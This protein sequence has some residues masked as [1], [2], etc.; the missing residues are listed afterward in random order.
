MDVTKRC[1]CDMMP[2]PVFALFA[3]ENWKVQP[4]CH[5]ANL[6][7]RPNVDEANIPEFRAEQRPCVDWK[8]VEHV[9]SKARWI[10]SLVAFYHPMTAGVQHY[11]HG[12]SMYAVCW[13]S[14]GEVKIPP[15]DMLPWTCRQIEGY[16]RAFLV[17][18]VL[19][20]VSANVSLSFKLSSLENLVLTNFTVR[21]WL[22][23]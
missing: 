23:Q 6:F 11:C 18:S 8:S 22:Q 12:L 3:A 21:I 1:A 4:L 20:V 15:W 10:Q 17:E 14:D 2:C 19:Y 9:V 16:G 5:G 13:P 7:P